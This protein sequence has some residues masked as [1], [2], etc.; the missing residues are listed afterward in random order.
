MHYAVIPHTES[1]EARLAG[2]FTFTDYAEF[3]SLVDRLCS[4]TAATIVFDL[5][6]VDFVDSAALGMLLLARD[7]TSKAQKRIVLRRPQTQVARMLTI[8]RFDELMTVD[9]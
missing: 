8:A 2:R 1:T 6:G 4:D 5:S 9:A 3:R 7:E